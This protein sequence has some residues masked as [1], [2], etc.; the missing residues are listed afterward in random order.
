[1]IWILS[2]LKRA[3]KDFIR[4]LRDREFWRIL[5]ESIKEMGANPYG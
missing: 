1:M 4:M 3:V 2:D 5:K